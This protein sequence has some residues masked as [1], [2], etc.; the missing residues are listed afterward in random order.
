MPFF[1]WSHPDCPLIV[2]GVTFL[3]QLYCL[4]ISMNSMSVM[5]N[6]RASAVFTVDEILSMAEQGAERRGSTTPVVPLQLQRGSVTS[7]HCFDNEQEVGPLLFLQI[8]SLKWHSLR[9]GLCPQMGKETY[10]G[11]GWGKLGS[12]WSA[13]GK[14]WA[15]YRHQLYFPLAGPEGQN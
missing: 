14:V 15:W 1:S 11:K 4:L 7:L 3:N 6:Q 8:S 10:L 12:S 2:T 5:E 13:C 9:L